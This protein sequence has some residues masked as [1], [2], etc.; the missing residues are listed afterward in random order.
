[1][2]AHGS[3]P[4][5]SE[6]ARSERIRYE[7][8]TRGGPARPTD[9]SAAPVEVDGDDLVSWAAAHERLDHERALKMTPQTKS[10]GSET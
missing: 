9:V 10:E 8:L 7:E 2:K 3:E 5:V 1:M 4:R 6:C